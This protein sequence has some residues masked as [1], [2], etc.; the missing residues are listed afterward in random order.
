MNCLRYQFLREYYKNETCKLI[1]VYE[2]ETR[3]SLHE[4]RND[5]RVIQTSDLKFV[6]EITMAVVQSVV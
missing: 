2:K 4:Y 1:R 5:L 6:T 3:E